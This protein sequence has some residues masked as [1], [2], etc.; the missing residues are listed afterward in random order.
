MDGRFETFTVL[1]SKINRNIR[2]IKNREMSDHDL[3]GAHIFCLY[4]L[5]LFGALTSTDLCDRCE[6]DKATISRAIAHLEAEG[7]IT[8]E[9]L[10]TKRY[11]SPLLL[12]KKGEQAGQTVV[13]KVNRVLD[14]VSVGLTEEERIAFY[15]SLEII[16]DNLEKISKD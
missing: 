11:N 9:T 1:I 16:S 7:Y 12:T 2:K 13:K 3:K 10:G 14:E 8:C 6:E 4:Y 15:R 5:Y